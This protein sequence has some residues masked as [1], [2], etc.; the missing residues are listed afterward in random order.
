[1]IR[2]VNLVRRLTAAA[3]TGKRALPR[4]AVPP[5]AASRHRGAVLWC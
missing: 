4:P 3:T 1:L 5:D 2:Q